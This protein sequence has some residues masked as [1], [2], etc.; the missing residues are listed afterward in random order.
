MNEKDLIGVTRTLEDVQRDLLT[1]ISPKTILL[2]HSLE[3]DLVAL[4]VSPFLLLFFPAS[5]SRLVRFPE[6]SKMPLII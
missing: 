5:L 6:L 4:K 1:F 2:G 3:S